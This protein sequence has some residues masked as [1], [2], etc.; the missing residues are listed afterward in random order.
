MY[1]SLRSYYRRKAEVNSSS[2]MVCVTPS[3]ML[4]LGQVKASQLF[5][6]FL[7]QK[8]VRVLS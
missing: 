3:E 5:F 1:F 8:E 4:L 7:E 2:A 6:R